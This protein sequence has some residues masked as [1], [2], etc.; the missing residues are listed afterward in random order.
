MVVLS[1]LQSQP[2]RWRTFVAN[3]V[4]DI[5]RVLNND[6]WRHVQSA[7][8]A[9]DIATRGIRASDLADFEVWWT[10]P[11]WLKKDLEFIGCDIPKTELEL[12]S[13]FHTILQEDHPIW[14]RFSDITRMKRVL[15]YCRRMSKKEGT[16][17][18]YKYLTTD[19]LE[20]VLVECIK[21]Y[22]NLVYGKEVEDLKKTGNV[23]P[24]S[25]LITLS[26]FLDENEVIRV[27]GRLQNASIADTTKH[28]IV[29]PSNQHITKLL[30]N[31]A[32]N[33]TLHGGI[34]L[35]MTYV[36]TKYWVISLKSAVKKCIRICKTCII[37]KA[38]TK[39]QFM[40]QLPAMRVNSH[41]PFLNSGVDYA[42]PIMMRTSKGRGHHATKGYVCLFVC[43]ATRAIHLEAVTDLTS[44]AFIAAFRRFVARRGHC[45][46]LWSDNGTNFIGAAKE[47]RDLFQRGTDNLAK[48][49]AELL[50]NDGTTAH[51]IP[52]RMPSYGGLWEAGV[53]S[54]KRHLARVSKDTKLTYE[55]MST[56][57]TQ[58]EACLNSRPLCQIDNTIE[59]PL[60]PDHFLVG[61]PLI[62]VPDLN[63][64]HHKIN[65]LTRW[66]L[67]QKMT[68]DFWHKWQTEYLNT[69]QQRYKWQVTV[70][71][72]AV[73]DIVIVKDENLPP[74]K[75][76]LGKIKQLHPGADNLV[77]VITIQCKGNNE[78]KRPLSKV[79][80]LPK[81]TDE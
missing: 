65:V 16:G 50:A 40:G 2:S 66:Q 21:Y 46:H 45:S 67:I 42:G 27:G 44:Q 43:M 72:P 12:K 57:L 38:K 30:I 68:Q 64:Q 26:P 59:T 37:H 62:S 39:N 1:W 25:S 78:L 41:R 53:Q 23:K 51:F 34:Q 35:M 56:L 17:T 32:H 22:Q 36:R 71:S 6:R 11:Q 61:E 5:T 19:E 29:I 77:R 4:A 75:W 14:E 70:P 7:D 28:P 73:G 10:G 69:L 52:P 63:Y 33:K 13:T 79:I 3:R 74:T 81:E 8:N 9:A 76:L 47:L 58:I 18:R 80:L 49:V 54:A 55:E 20:R 60:T 31:E 24:R 15:A 48:E